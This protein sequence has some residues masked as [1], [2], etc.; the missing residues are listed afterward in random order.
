MLIL[1]K[2]SSV[3]RLQGENQVLKEMAYNDNAQNQTQS[4]TQNNPC[5]NQLNEFVGCMNKYGDSAMCQQ[6]SDALSKC[7]TVNN[8]QAATSASTQ[9]AQ[10]PEGFSFN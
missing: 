5:A 7:V 3:G 4:Q 10:S 6:F 9:M 2:G 8:P 1:I